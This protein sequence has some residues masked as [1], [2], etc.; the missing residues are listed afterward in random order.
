MSS[1]DSDRIAF[2]AWMK[3]MNLRLVDAEM[4]LGCSRSALRRYVKGD[5]DIPR[6]IM[7]ACA[8]LAQGIR[9]IGA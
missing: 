3:R 5:A 4:L 8:A 6:Y 9:P 7:L 2:C 1:K